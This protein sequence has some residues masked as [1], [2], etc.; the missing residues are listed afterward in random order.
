MAGVVFAVLVVGILFTIGLYLLIESETSN[1]T[2]V[3][4]KTA[5]REAKRQG[6]LRQRRRSQ[7]P[8]QTDDRSRDSDHGRS[9]TEDDDRDLGWDNR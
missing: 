8:G 7:R 5:E 3:D 4:R 2:V 6:G 1:P 9:G